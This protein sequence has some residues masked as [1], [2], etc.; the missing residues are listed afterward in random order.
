MLIAKGSQDSVRLN[1][2]KIVDVKKK[3]LIVIRELLSLLNSAL[4]ATIK[5]GKYLIAY[6]PIW[7]FGSST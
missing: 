5:L 4:M 1:R 2:N 7:F 6:L 3:E